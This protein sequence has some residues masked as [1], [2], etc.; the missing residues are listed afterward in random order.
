MVHWQAVDWQG[1]YNDYIDVNDNNKKIKKKSTD[2]AF[3]EFYEDM[4]N[5]HGV[6]RIY[7]ILMN[8]LPM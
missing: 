5:P 1:R 3:R 8:L 7:Y 4:Y 6:E 2:E